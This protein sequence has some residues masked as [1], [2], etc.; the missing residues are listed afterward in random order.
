MQE[1]AHNTAD[2]PQTAYASAQALYR[3]GNAADAL[4]LLELS[5]NAHP[6]S[7]TLNL[8][9]VCCIALGRGSE[10]ESYC[11]RAVEINP[12]FAE[13][14][15]N[16]GIVLAAMGRLNEAEACY[17]RALDISP[18]NPHAH[19]N[20]GRIFEKLDAPDAAL[21][22]HRRA[23]ECSPEEPSAHTNL[24]ALCM[25]LARFREA[26]QS[27]RHAATLKPYEANAHFNHGTALKK[28]GLFNEAES[29]YRQALDLHPGRTDARI[30][31][32]HLLLGLGQMREGWDLFEAR[33]QAGGW[34]EP[35]LTGL[36]MWQGE[37]LEGRSL[38]V[39]AEQGYGDSLQ[40][41]RYLPMLKALGLVK[42]TFAC[43]PALQALLATIEGVDACIV[44]DDDEAIAAHDYQCLLMSLPHRFDT[45]LETVPA[46][47]PYL[48]VPPE[49]ARSWRGRL[50]AGGFK[51]GLVWA[52]DPR[53]HSAHLQAVDRLR[54]L[55]AQ[56]YLPILRVPGVTFIS[57][58][59]G[60]STQSQIDTLP[61][62]FRPLDPMSE[63]TDFADTAAIIDQ[64]DLVITVDTSVAHLAGA[65]NRPVWILSRYDGCWR[66]L[67]RKESSSLW[68]PNARLFR[69]VRPGE[70][71]D[72]IETVASALD[73]AART[74]AQTHIASRDV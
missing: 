27:F 31:L 48:R 66:W 54:S 15:N 3:S 43:P 16:L 73:E 24:G 42:L 68:Y 44:A 9:A 5:I 57:L 70:W 63:V 18:D 12:E 25:K 46:T 33:Y 17:R 51:V 69:Q 1:R 58:Q 62:D 2:E 30:N 65:L 40:F 11:R 61:S 74:R 53:A 56:A 60:A 59:K 14:H 72:V 26:E 4:D 36:P 67:Y 45:T 49:R 20:L 29:A 22:A 64:L 35:P 21:T 41:C 6:D 10:G 50:S 28:L 52:G 71:S 32:A 7:A 13:A 47:L 19:T 34:F 8:A 37:C 23:V 55:S 39:W 38:I